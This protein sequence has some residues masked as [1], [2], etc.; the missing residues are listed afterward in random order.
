MTGQEETVQIHL[1]PLLRVSNLSSGP[2]M[3]DMSSRARSGSLAKKILTSIRMLCSARLALPTCENPP[4]YDTGS[5]KD[6]I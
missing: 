6:R 4:S 5:S 2:S 1:L 3:K